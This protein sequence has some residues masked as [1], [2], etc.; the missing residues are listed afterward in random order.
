MWVI[1]LGG[2]GFWCLSRVDQIV[3]IVQQLM[4]L[5]GTGHWR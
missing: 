5:G 2:P 4:W 1:G 3:Q